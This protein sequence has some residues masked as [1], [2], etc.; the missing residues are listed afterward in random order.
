MSTE[1]LPKKFGEYGG[2]FVPE[3]LM[4]ALIELEEAYLDTK[5]DPIFQSALQELLKN[6]VGR[7]TPLTYAR[8]I[9][10]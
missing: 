8:R 4:P 5:D 6:Y 9:T 7:P 2:Q 10:D 1:K 3:T